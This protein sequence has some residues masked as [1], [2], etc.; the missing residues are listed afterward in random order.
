MKKQKLARYDGYE[1]KGDRKEL[2]SYG[3]QRRSNTKK[4]M[5][6]TEMEDLENY[7]HYLRPV[8]SSSRIQSQRDLNDDINLHNASQKIQYKSAKVRRFKL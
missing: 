5:I 7:E 2:N 4:K 3:K 1:P 6:S 8:I